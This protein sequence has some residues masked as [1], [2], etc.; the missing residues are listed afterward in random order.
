[1][2][3]DAHLSQCFGSQRADRVEPEPRIGGIQARLEGDQRRLIV[4]G[5]LQL[6]L[7]QFRRPVGVIPVANVDYGKLSGQRQEE[8]IVTPG[9][10]TPLNDESIAVIVGERD[11]ADLRLQEVDERAPCYLDIGYRGGPDAV[12]PEDLLKRFGGSSPCDRHG[13]R[14]QQ[15]APEERATSAP[16]SDLS[17][18]RPPYGY[19]M[20]DVPDVHARGVVAAQRNGRVN[21]GQS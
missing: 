6:D 12:L 1:L 4:E 16:L 19:Q 5:D 20:M 14:Y 15:H 10:P 8:A 3:L 11:P 9:T 7:P 21:L 18:A 2:R 13:E 17:V